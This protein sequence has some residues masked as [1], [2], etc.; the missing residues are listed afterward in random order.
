MQCPRVI[1]TDIKNLKKNE[2][3]KE[4]IALVVPFGVPFEVPFGVPF[5]V[6]FGVPFEVPFGVPF[7]VP[8]GVPFVVHFGPVFFP[9]FLAEFHL[10]PV[11]FEPIDDRDADA[12]TRFVSVFTAFISCGSIGPV[13][14][15]PFFVATITCC[16]FAA[17]VCCT[18]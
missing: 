18:L 17:V 10:N 3:H 7:V 1:R 11:E 13:L 4:S 14:L 9:G 2:S 8:F 15:P 12:F 6:P 5:V 16:C